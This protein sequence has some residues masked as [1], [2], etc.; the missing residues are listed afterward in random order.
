METRA[1]MGSALDSASNIPERRAPII[2]ILPAQLDQYTREELIELLN[3]HNL[4]HHGADDDSDPPGDERS[5]EQLQSFPEELSDSQD[6]GAA[7]SASPATTPRI[8]DDVNALSLSLRPS[9]SYLGV[10]S[11]LAILRVILSLDPTCR[12]FTPRETRNNGAEAKSRAFQIQ[13][14]APTLP[15]SVA[16]WSDVPVI[17]AYFRAVH[18][19]I[20]L[21]DE[22]RFR[23]IYAE[24]KRTDSRWHLLLNAVLAMGSVAATEADDYTHCAFYGRAKQYLTIDLLGSAHIET[25]QA[26]AI[27]SGLYLHYNNEPTLANSLSGVVFRMATAIGLHRDYLDNSSASNDPKILSTVELRRRIWHC[28]IIMDAWTAIFLGRPTLGRAGPG[29]TTKKPQQP[30]VSEIFSSLHLC[31]FLTLLNQSGSGIITTL[32]RENVDCSIVTTRMEDFLAEKP[33]LGTK[34]RTELDTSL[35]EWLQNSSSRRDRVNPD[36]SGFSPGIVTAMNIMRWRCI[37]A[38]VLVYR[39]LLLWYAVSRSSMTTISEEK[40]RAITQC[41]ELAAELISDIEKTWHISGRCQISGWIA[42]WLLYQAS[43]VPLLSLYCDHNDS[44]VLESSSLQIQS[45]MQTFT[46]LERWSPAAQRS[47]EVVKRLYEAG[48][49]YSPPTP[50]NAGDEASHVP[51]EPLIGETETY[52][53]AVPDDTPS[54]FGSMP[55]GGDFFVDNFYDLSWGN[56]QDQNGGFL[57]SLNWDGS[58]DR[59]FEG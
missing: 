32:L 42:T 22:D 39:P 29:Y 38:R 57:S 26:L 17:N 8:T 1:T 2:R 28:I 33:I 50:L 36:L 14:N 21:I 51:P 35:R 18:P 19:I 54:S 3:K 48:I 41:R 52:L 56:F 53:H 7:F 5:L 43:M 58:F 25:V 6:E 40:R 34:N 31:T 49:S 23:E 30:I 20:P 24:G 12:A 37:S 13:N 11:V 47:L 46:S 15:R 27:L 59:G 16:L 44:V 9:S 10:S 45:A 55:I 4:A